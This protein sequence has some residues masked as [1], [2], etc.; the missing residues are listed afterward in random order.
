M[1]KL[2]FLRPRQVVRAL[3]RAGFTLRKSKSG[4]RTYVKGSP[5]RDRPLPF[6]G[7][8]TGNATLHHRAGGNDRGRVPQLPLRLRRLFAPEQAVEPEVGEFL[9]NGVGAKACVEVLEVNFVE[10]LILI[11]AGEDERL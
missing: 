10:Q 3:E 9:L 4:H 6:D 11:E 1:T 7:H 8:Q 2:P 5:A